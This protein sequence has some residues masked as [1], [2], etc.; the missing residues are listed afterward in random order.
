M[1][2]RESVCVD[3]NLKDTPRIPVAFAFTGFGV[4]STSFSQWKLGTGNKGLESTHNDN[5][6]P[7]LP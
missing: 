3:V 5:V 7:G 2:S 4:V 1:L 6:W